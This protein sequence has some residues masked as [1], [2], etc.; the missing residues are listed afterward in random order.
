MFLYLFKILYQIYKNFYKHF[1]HLHLMQLFSTD[2]TVFS[3]YYQIYLLSLKIW[4]NKPQKLLNIR[5]I[6]FS[7]ANQPKTSPNLNFCSIK[8]T[9]RATY[10]C[11]M[12][13]ELHHV[14]TW[15][16]LLFILIKIFVCF[17]LRKV[18]KI[19][20]QS[21]KI[22]QM[23]FIIFFNGLKPNCFNHDVSSLNLC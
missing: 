8:T 10:I 21:W 12:T 5:P 22:K 19:F 14:N 16:K 1:F 2:I 20:G 15:T 18:Q 6:F 3:K 9:H 23:P 17:Y 11:I 13:L 7:I 4:K